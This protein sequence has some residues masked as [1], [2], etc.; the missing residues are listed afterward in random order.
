M[1]RRKRRRFLKV[2]MKQVSLEGVLKA[3]NSQRAKT[4]LE[5]QERAQER[6]LVQQQLVQYLS[7]PSGAGAGTLPPSDSFL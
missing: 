5:P 1:K 7:R 3:R 6:P 2:R 4:Q